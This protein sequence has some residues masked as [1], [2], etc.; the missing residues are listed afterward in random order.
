MAGPAA[1]TAAAETVQVTIQGLRFSPAEV[2]A[3]VGDTIEWINR[4][5]IAHT[6]TAR[7]SWDV[8]IP[9]GGVGRLVIDRGDEMRDYICR[10]HPNMK[11]R[12]TPVDD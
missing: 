11:G 1:A 9:P 10:F 6:A 5:F 12:I 3:H 2:S 8:V 7:G 4:D